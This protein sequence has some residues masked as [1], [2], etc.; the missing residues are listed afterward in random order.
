[1]IKTIGQRF[2]Y[3]QSI[4]DDRNVENMILKII[5]ISQ[6]E[7]LK[8]NIRRRLLPIYDKKGKGFYIPDFLLKD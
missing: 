6:V 8:K 7:Q 1:M 4:I 2:D 3:L 5:S